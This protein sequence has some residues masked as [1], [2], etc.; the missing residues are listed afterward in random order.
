M[1]KCVVPSSSW[2]CWI[3]AF[4]LSIANWWILCSTT[5][6]FCDDTTTVFRRR[7][8]VTIKEPETAHDIKSSKSAATAAAAR[9]TA[10]QRPHTTQHSTTRRPASDRVTPRSSLK[11]PSNVNVVVLWC[12]VMRDCDD[13]IINNH[14]RS[15]FLVHNAHLVTAV[16]DTFAAVTAVFALG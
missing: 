11:P 6:K 13:V 1:M 14:S 5:N 10:S 3:T 12:D 2:N 9:G 4:Y 8:H 7:E 15:V 16:I